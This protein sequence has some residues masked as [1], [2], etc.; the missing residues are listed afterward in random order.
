MADVVAP[1]L[2]R[3]INEERRASRLPAPRRQLAEGELS[4][5]VF[6]ENA[7][8]SEFLRVAAK[9]AVGLFRPTKHTE[10]VWCDAA[11]PAWCAKEREYLP[12]CRFRQDFE[13]S[14]GNGNPSPGNPVVPYPM[15]QRCP[16]PIRHET[17][18]G[19]HGKAAE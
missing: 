12:V 6:I 1:E 16:A 5:P 11:A 10:A 3:F 7:R 17:Q 4:H 8:V 14:T 9:R 19:Q 2:A 18:G 15:T 13:L